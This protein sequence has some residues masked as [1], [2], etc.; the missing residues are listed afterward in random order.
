MPRGERIKGRKAMLRMI[1]EATSVAD[2]LLVIRYLVPEDCV[3]RRAGFTV[4]RRFRR[5][6]DRN[7]VRRRL[8]EVYRTHREELPE[9]GCFLLIARAGAEH[10]SFA[11]LT[12]A[13]TSLAHRLADMASETADTAL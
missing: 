5:S 1:R 13:F 2:R 4:S 9:K 11:E 12:D 7:L 3:A 8:R 6:V 10:A